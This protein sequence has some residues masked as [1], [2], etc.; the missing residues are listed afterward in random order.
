[1][2]RRQISGE[3]LNEPSN[4]AMVDWSLETDDLYAGVTTVD[5]AIAQLRLVLSGDFGRYT[6]VRNLE[7]PTS[8]RGLG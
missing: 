5:L 8:I 3:S 4:P 2:L 7:Q 1:L 6:P